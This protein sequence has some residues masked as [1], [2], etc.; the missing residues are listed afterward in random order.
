MAV[1]DDHIDTAEAL[2]LILRSVGF[3]AAVFTRS[4]DFLSEF[5]KLDPALVLLDLAMPECDGLQVLRALRTTLG[6][7]VPVI[8]LSAQASSADVTEL[9]KLG[10]TEVLRKPLVIETLVQAVKR[11]VQS[12]IDA[13]S[14][15]DEPVQH[16]AKLPPRE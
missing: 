6:T 11:G 4:L 16:A 15:M 5:P 2:G 13:A 8:V 1:V 12:A 14:A 9:E 3:E 10:V 7:A